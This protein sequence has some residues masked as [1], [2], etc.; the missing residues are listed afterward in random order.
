MFDACLFPALEIT[1]TLLAL[2]H[3]LSPHT[4][5]ALTLRA[6]QVLKQSDRFFAHRLPDPVVAPLP[7]QTQ[8][9]LPSAMQQLQQ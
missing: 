6:L 9:V 3:P 7:I 2:T 8:E 1:S 5:K 4:P